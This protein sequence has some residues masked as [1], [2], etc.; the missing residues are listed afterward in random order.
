MVKAKTQITMFLSEEEKE[1]ISKKATEFSLP[2]ASFCRSEILRRINSE[3]QP[4]NS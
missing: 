4:I 2:V 1:S 3:V